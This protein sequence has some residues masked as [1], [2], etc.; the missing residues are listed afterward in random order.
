M[1]E[2]KQGK[3]AAAVNKTPINAVCMVAALA[4]QM[5]SARIHDYRRLRATSP[6]HYRATAD[7]LV[8]YLYN[9]SVSQCFHLSLADRDL[10]ALPIP[11]MA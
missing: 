3:S 4:S 9:L 2:K 8:L 10:L 6:S 11:T 1:A 5:E 7:P